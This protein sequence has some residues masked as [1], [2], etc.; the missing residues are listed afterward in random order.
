MRVSRRKFVKAGAMMG[1]SAVAV[2]KGAT[3]VFGQQADVAQPGLF[4]IPDD[5][6]AEIYRLSEESFSRHINTNFRI[7]TSPLTA[8]NL[9]LIKVSRRDS[10]SSEKPAKTPEVDCFSVVFRGPRKLA[11]E[12]RT[13]RVEHGQMGAF[14][15]FITPVDDHKKQRR[16]QAVFNRV[17]Q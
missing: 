17:K 4:K 2:L 11:L 14:D 12:S 7:F 5:S 13:Y 6:E 15:L 10:P 9:E 3:S 1:L 16:Y 8:I